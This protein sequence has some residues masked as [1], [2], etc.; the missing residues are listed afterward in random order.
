MNHHINSELGQLD[1]ST[2]VILMV[3]AAIVAVAV[4]RIK[5]PYTVALV[6]V[7]LALGFFHALQPV[8]LT[9]HIVIYFSTRF[10]V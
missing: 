2:L 5:I 1:I 10:T 4:K 8:A 7:G 3:I 6:V 9:E